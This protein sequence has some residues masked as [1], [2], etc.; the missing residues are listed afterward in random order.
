MAYRL[1]V[2]HVM[3]VIQGL[4]GPN[5]PERYNG[6]CPVCGQ[7]VVWLVQV[8]EGYPM[9]APTSTVLQATKRA[10]RYWPIYNQVLA[11]VTAAY[12]SEAESSGTATFKLGTKDPL[13]DI[14]S[15]PGK[16]C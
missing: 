9:A 5:V 7:A 14:N 12:S 16:R 11:A 3:C 1:A 15:L 13:D 6:G 2:C 4:E 8:N 10:T